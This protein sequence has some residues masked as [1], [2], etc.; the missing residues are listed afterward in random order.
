MNKQLL[1]VFLVS[2]LV[3]CGGTTDPELEAT[4][5]EPSREEVRAETPEVERD[6][7]IIAYCSP[8]YYEIIYYSDCTRDTIVGTETVTCKGERY[9]DGTKTSY[10]DAGRLDYCPRC[11]IS[12]MRPT[13]CQ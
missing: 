7:Q 6:A 11:S 3:A 9:L 10:Y 5:N 2:M 13:S 1:G 4:P 8:Y 12:P